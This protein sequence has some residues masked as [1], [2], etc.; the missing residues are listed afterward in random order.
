[1]AK[2]NMPAKTGETSGNTGDD[3]KM[4]LGWGNYKLMLIGLGL[5]ILGFILMSGG[6][7]T[8]A[9]YF[10]E[11]MFSFRRITLAPI[12]VISGFALE[13]YAILKKTKR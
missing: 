13:I 11:S 2:N 3:S 6:T 4:A 7:G 8:T 9:D 12:I 5:I 1:M 10:D